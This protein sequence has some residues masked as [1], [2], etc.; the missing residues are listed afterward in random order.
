M[1]VSSLHRNEKK[2]RVGIIGASTDAGWARFAHVPALQALSD[3][4]ELVAVAT[5]KQESAQRAAHAFGARLAFDNAHALAQSPDVDLVVVSVKAPQHEAAVTAA[6]EAG[7]NVLCEWP[8]GSNAEQAANMEKLARARGVIGVVG[9]QARS[10]PEAHYVRDLLAQ[11]TIGE[12]LAVNVYGVHPHWGLN[13][14]SAYSADIRSGANLLTIPGGHTLDLV[15]YLCGDPV[16]LTA[17]LP[18]QIREAFAA[19]KQTTITVS[20]PSQ[21]ALCGTLPSGAVLTLQLLGFVPRSGSIDIH[22]AGTEGELILRGAGGA[23]IAE[24]E[25]E[26]RGKTD[27]PQMLSV[28][29]DYDRLPAAGAARSVAYAYR[30][31]ALD[32]RAGK[33]PAIGFARGLQLHRVLDAIRESSAA[34]AAVKV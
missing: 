24:L 33:T 1:S 17:Q 11:K 30:Q 2:I 8:F 10:T 32:L 15:S 27:K 23:Q 20:A 4:Y 31:L 34:N 25:I 6:L 19:D 28:P 5:T 9:L 18:N 16:T 13:T 12:V 7:K 3:D 26:M 21:V 14:S 29:C 22:I